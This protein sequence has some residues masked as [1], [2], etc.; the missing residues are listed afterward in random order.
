M[1]TD[2][3]GGVW[4]YAVDLSVGL[5]A[6]GV[7]VVLVGLGPQASDE[8]RAEAAAIEGLEFIDTGLPLDWTASEPAAIAESGA[9]VRGLARRFEV[10]LVHLNTPALAAENP[11]PVPVLGAC[12]SCLTT[13]WLAV[14]DG[15]PPE[16]FRW[17]ARAHWAGLI[18]SQVTIAPSHA[19]AQATAVAYG[20]PTPWVVHNGGRARAAVCQPRNRRV[21]TA[22]RL[23]DAGKNV[24]ALDAAAA[25]IDAPVHAAGAL[26][27]PGGA[28]TVLAHALPLGPMPRAKLAEH[29]TGSSV[30]CST[31]LYEPFGLTVLEAAQAGCALVLSDI[32]T[33]RELWDGAALF[34]PANQP[35]EIAETLQRLLDDVPLARTLGAAAAAR[36]ARYSVEA[37]TGGVLDLYR[38]LAPERFARRVKDAAA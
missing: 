12:H 19:F 11:M 9:L 6:A 32:P 26:A 38:L 16:D 7:E 20:M 33:F 27:G 15:D 31:A 8:Q 5:S 29:M 25:F 4:S 35:R 14:Q 2:A 34:V 23:W 17:R 10:D 37:M 30:F 3:V 22:G 36:A 28:Q 1:T 18:A 24:A 13:W 21:L